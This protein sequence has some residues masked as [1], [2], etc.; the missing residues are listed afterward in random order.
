[1]ILGYVADIIHI[2]GIFLVANS[3]DKP[4]LVVDSIKPRVLL[5]AMADTYAYPCTHAYT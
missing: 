3:T 1:M 5:Y 2:S 4:F